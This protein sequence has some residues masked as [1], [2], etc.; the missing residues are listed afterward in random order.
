MAKLT[1][2][3]IVRVA[4]EIREDPE[5]ELAD[6]LEEVLGEERASLFEE[7]KVAKLLYDEGLFK[8]SECLRWLDIEDER[9]EEP[10]VCLHC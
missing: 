5:L 4:D 10:G 8:C 2:D 7:S 9:D 6:V 1:E 3:E